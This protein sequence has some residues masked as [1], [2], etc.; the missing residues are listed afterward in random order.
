V[1]T[2]PLAGIIA[3]TLCVVIVAAST[4]Q[5]RAPASLTTLIEEYRHGDAALALA[6]FMKWD[7]KRMAVEYE[8][9]DTQRVAAQR[10]LPAETDTPDI[11]ALIMLNTAA[12][13]EIGEFTAASRSAA[14]GAFHYQAALRS[15]KGLVPRASHAEVRAFCRDWFVLT[16]SLWLSARHCSQAATTA[17]DALQWLGPEAQLF[18]AAASVAEAQMGP[19]ENGAELDPACGQQWGAS[20]LT[21]H[22]GFLIHAPDRENAERWLQRAVALDPSLAEAHLRL[23]RVLFWADRPT[24][25][26]RELE[27]AI[28]AVASAERPFVGY[29][30]ALFLGQLHEEAHRVEEAMRA[31]EQAIR[32][33][34][35]GRAAYLALGHLLLMSGPAEEGWARVRAAFGETGDVNSDELDPWL[36][37]RHG[38]AWQASDRLHALEGWVRR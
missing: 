13:V 16:T 6:E 36:L 12:A 28:A 29:L 17:H 15:V 4:R 37:Y 33:N 34:P 26:R 31:Y 23:G 3:C 7:A 35:R 19:F 27:R 10:F 38:Q 32:F 9:W 14:F 30:A 25:A 1:G 18:L 5:S 11:A 21:W 22:G 8:A 20:T 24:Y 2:R